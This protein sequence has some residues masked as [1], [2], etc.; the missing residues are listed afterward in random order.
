[1]W[2]KVL[3]GSESFITMVGNVF[4]FCA[5][6]ELCQMFLTVTF[7]SIGVGLLRRVTRAFGRAR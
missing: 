7:T 4:T 2:E 3:S 5:G 1:M 6:N